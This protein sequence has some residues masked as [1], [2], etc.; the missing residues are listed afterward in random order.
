MVVGCW[1]LQILAVLFSVSAFIA[2]EYGTGSADGTPRVDGVG[3][4]ST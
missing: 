4:H 1:L 2:E 3:A